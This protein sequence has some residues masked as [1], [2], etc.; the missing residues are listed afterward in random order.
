VVQWQYKPPPPLAVRAEYYVS[1][2]LV[3]EAQTHVRAILRI[4]T[5]VTST[6]AHLDGAILAL[7]RAISSGTYVSQA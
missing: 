1:R 4:N 3:L 7:E 5:P 2:D 6:K